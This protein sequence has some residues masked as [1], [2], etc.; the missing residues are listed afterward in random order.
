M[1]A[2]S[3]AAVAFDIADAESE[4][5][6]AGIAAVSFVWEKANEKA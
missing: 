3:C 1:I 6:K 4:A 5:T 2:E